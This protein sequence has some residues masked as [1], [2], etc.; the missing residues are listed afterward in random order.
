M[1]QKR[2]FNMGTGVSSILMVFAMLCITTFGVL[3]LVSANADYKLTKKS[4]AA[5][6]AYYSADKHAAEMLSELDS[7][8][9]VARQ[10]ASVPEESTL[11]ALISEAQLSNVQADAIRNSDA[12][13]QELFFFVLT[14]VLSAKEVYLI[15]EQDNNLIV[16]YS[17]DINNEKTLDVTAEV[18]GLDTKERYKLISYKTAGS[19]EDITDDDFHV[20]P[21]PSK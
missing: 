18:Y 14:S 1:Q 19:S 6:N 10:Y 12:V 8:I 4:E 17:V 16:S 15:S 5:A 11:N 3:S 13:G 9:S 21:G 2:I 7:L 20:W